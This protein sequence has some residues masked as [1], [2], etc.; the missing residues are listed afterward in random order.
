[1][2]LCPAKVLGDIAACDLDRRGRGA[3][4]ELGRHLAEQPPD[5]TFEVANAGFPGVLGD[6]APNGILANGHLSG[7]EPVALQLAAQQVIAGDGELFLFRVA[8]QPDD[9]HPVEQGTGDGISDVS[10]RDEQHL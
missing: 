7:A 6:D 9:L 3:G 4:F 2:E 1:M 8:V 10:R 5:F